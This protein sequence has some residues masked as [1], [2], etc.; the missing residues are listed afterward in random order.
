M[1]L[2]TA[3]QYALHAY[4]IPGNTKDACKNKIVEVEKNLKLKINLFPIPVFVIRD[5]DCPLIFL[6][7]RFQQNDIKLGIKITD[8][9]CLKVTFQIPK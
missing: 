2:T 6:Q 7:R 8:I 3:L 4:Y 5:T 9:K 1:C